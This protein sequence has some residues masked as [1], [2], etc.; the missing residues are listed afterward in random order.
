ML[1]S[2]ILF[3]KNVITD[4]D[5]QNNP[6]DTPDS[7]TPADKIGKGSKVVGNIKKPK[8]WTR[9]KSK[10]SSVFNALR[11]IG[12]FKFNL[13]LG[14]ILG[15]NNLYRLAKEYGMI[16]QMNNCSRRIQPDHSVEFNGNIFTSEDLVKR[17]NHRVY[18]IKSGIVEELGK[19]LGGALGAD[20]MMQYLPDLA[21]VPGLNRLFSVSSFATS[22]EAIDQI[23]EATSPKAQELAW[24]AGDYIVGD[25][26]S[27]YTLQI[28]SDCGKVSESQF[29]FDKSSLSS[30]SS[31]STSSSQQQTAKKLN[32]L[33]DE[34][35]QDNPHLRDLIK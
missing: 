11:R 2:E 8:I 10:F 13:I 19:A 6:N 24:L 23:L 14:L 1:V 33:V 27:N 34:I 31:G 21:K 4:D 30:T 15:A 28:A 12:T 22:R 16:L 29:T 7:T 20:K 35:L 3:E 17:L 32:A 18:N 26:I 5:E 9:L 25:W